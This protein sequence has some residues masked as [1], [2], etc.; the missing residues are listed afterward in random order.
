MGC[1]IIM[2]YLLARHMVRA[3]A[4]HQWHTRKIRLLPSAI[5]GLHYPTSL[6]PEISINGPYPRIEGA[7][8]QEEV[9]A[10]CSLGEQPLN[11]ASPWCGRD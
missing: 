7:G 2:E 6:S 9:A 5:L 8:A 4:M 3:R 11:A 10:G 1:E